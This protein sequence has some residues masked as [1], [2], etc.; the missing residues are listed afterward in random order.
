MTNVADFLKRV[1]DKTGY[2]RESYVDRNIPTSFS[3]IVVM[4]FYGD[5]RSE[6]ILSSMLL[7]RIKQLHNSKYFILCSYPGRAGMYPY[8]D[9]YWS[10]QDEGA[11]KSL[12]DSSTGMDNSDGKKILF[13]EQQLNKYFENLLSIEDYYKYYNRGFNK[14]FFDEFKWIL[15]SLPSIP[16]TKI[17]FNRNLVQRAGYK[18]FIYPSRILRAWSRGKEVN[19]RSNIDFWCAL[20]NKLSDNGFTPVVYQDYSTYDISS[21]LEGKCVYFSENKILDVLGV[22]RTTGCVL[23]VFSGISRW[24][25][26]ARTPFVSC[27][28]RHLYNETKEYEIDCLCN[29]MLPYKYVFSFPTIIE[30]GYWNELIGTIVNKLESFIPGLNRDEWPSTAEQSVVVPYALVKDKKRKK[31]GSRFIKVERI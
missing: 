24:A 8:V 30:S 27:M 19:V 21:S 20:V 6:F 3:N 15:Y 7:H 12:V 31:I 13:Q 23:D 22:M 2:K 28:E 9:E 16:S 4:L 14:A 25:T 10:L 5:I 17:E 26:A 18:V 1:A 29:N 11:I